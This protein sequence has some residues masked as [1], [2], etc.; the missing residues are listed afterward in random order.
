VHTYTPDPANPGQF[1]VV[2]K[3]GSGSSLI[4]ANLSEADAQQLVAG[5][6]G[7]SLTGLYPES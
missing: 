5:L 2:F 3:N 6:N 1:Q 7:G 4:K